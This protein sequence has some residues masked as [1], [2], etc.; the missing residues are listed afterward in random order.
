MPKNER[1]LVLFWHIITT[2]V[3]DKRVR[4]TIFTKIKI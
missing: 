3:F 4:G 1:F 2:F